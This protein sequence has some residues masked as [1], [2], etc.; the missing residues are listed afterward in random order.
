MLAFEAARQA[1]EQQLVVVT[2]VAK[3]FGLDLLMVTVVG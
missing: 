1:A 3:V 2:V